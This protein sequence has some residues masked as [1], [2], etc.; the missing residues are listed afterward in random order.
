MRL[1]FSSVATAAV[2]SHCSAIRRQTSA[3]VIESATYGNAHNAK[4]A[5]A[6]RIMKIPRLA[7]K[8]RMTR[9]GAAPV[10]SCWCSSPMHCPGPGRRTLPRKVS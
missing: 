6:V 8:R 5:K 9:D 10:G 1:A 3:R 4:M 7:P 2:R